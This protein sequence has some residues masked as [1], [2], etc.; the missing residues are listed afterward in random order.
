MD[1]VT[2]LQNGKFDEARGDCLLR[3]RG[4]RW[5]GGGYGP[6]VCGPVIVEAVAVVVK[7]R[8]PMPTSRALGQQIRLEKRLGRSW[9]LHGCVVALGG[10]TRADGPR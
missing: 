4:K 5:S 1:L 3:R 9:P 2:P 8:H 10:E 6:G 7:G